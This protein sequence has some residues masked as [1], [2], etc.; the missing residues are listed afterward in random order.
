MYPLFQSFLHKRGI[1]FLCILILSLISTVFFSNSHLLHSQEISTISKSIPL[2]PRETFFAQAPEDIAVK[3]SPNG[4]KISFLRVYEGVLNVW[5]QN[6]EDKQEAIPATKSKDSI[7]RYYW[8]KNNEQLLFYQDFSGDEN[9]HIYSVD[10]NSSKVIDLTPFENIQARLVRQSEK[11]PDEIIVAINNRV[12]T[13][14]DLWIINTRTGEGRLVYENKEEFGELFVDHN[15]QPRIGKKSDGQGGYNIFILDSSNGDWKPFIHF[16]REN[17]MTSR[18]LDFSADN[19]RL[20]YLDSTN[21]NTAA[22]YSSKINSDRLEK[23]KIVSNERSDLLDVTLDPITKNPRAAIS[24]F[25]R[26]QYSIIDPKIRADM[27]YLQNFSDGDLYLLDSS[28]DDQKWIVAYAYDNKPMHY[29]LYKRSKKAAI[30]LFSSNP[31]LE[32]LPL[33]S[34]QPLIITSRDGLPLVSYLSMPRQVPQK[35]IPLVLWVHGGPWA[36]DEWG[37]N[38]IHQWL[39]NRGYAVL[40]VNFRGSVGFGKNFVNA[41]NRQWSK[42]MQDDLIDAVNWS[43]EKGIADPKKICIGGASYGGYATLVGLTSTPDMFACGVDMVG[44]SNLETLLESYP[45]YMKDELDEVE[46]RIGRGD[47]KEF[48]RSISPLYKADKISKPLLI[49]HG[50]ND[51]RVSEK[52]SSQIV[53]AMKK[54]QKPIIYVLFPDEGHA[55]VKIKN[56]I[57]FYAIM[58]AFLAKELGGRF[59][60]I[61]DDVKESSA[62]IVEGQELIIRN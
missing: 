11:S 7:F 49:A 47:D 20:Y 26:V 55:F 46:Y 2:I 19:T 44:L 18:I 21:S 24:K 62:I 28:S 5:T 35:N 54:H 50:K 10:L 22:L 51:I 29:Y 45:P 9:S 12:P 41:A 43:I 14:H 32:K 39:N 42:K 37:Y 3:I 59:Q 53:E 60:K 6:I 61:G 56:D 36:R 15:Q 34:M 27:E 48:L 4:K 31:E 38:V 30:F 57:A 1:H 40:S 23:E 13:S 52:A 58:E 33:T 25:L 8:A 16:D 17:S